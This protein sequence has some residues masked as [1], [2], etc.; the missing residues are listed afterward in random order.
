MY[1][2]ES[3]RR[4]TSLVLKRISIKGTYKSARGLHKLAEP[5]DESG[6]CYSVTV[7]LGAGEHKATIIVKFDD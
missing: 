7:V 4:K 2:L 5:C 1:R 6:R 3:K